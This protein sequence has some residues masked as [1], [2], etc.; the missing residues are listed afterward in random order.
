MADLY[1]DP[2]QETV[3]LEEV[4]NVCYVRKNIVTG[5]RFQHRG[6]PHDGKW[7]STK[8]FEV[9][10]AKIHNV[11][12]LFPIQAKHDPLSLALELARGGGGVE[13]YRGFAWR[14]R[15]RLCHLWRTSRVYFAL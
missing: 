5:I 9:V 8:L 4:N 12:K 2:R 14:G 11:T 13:L 1:I 15:H 7:M 10:R 6:A 3:A